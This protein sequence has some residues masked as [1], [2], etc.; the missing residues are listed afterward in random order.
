[1]R[2]TA[3]GILCLRGAFPASTF[4]VLFNWRQQPLL[5]QGE[6]VAIT[7]PPRQAP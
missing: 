2:D 7:D 5:D 1:L 4:V 6:D 3:L